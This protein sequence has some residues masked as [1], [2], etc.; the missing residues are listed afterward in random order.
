M[1][2]C[3]LRNVRGRSIEICDIF[4]GNLIGR[5][6][7]LI[8]TSDHH[9][10]FIFT[11]RAI[12]Y[13]DPF[14]VFC[15]FVSFFIVIFMQQKFILQKTDTSFIVFRAS[16]THTHTHTVQNVTQHATFN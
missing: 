3:A 14:F 8:G 1:F 2:L 13:K 9:L 12:C 7:Y 15:F 10:N 16:E 5:N 4:A 11:L 6:K